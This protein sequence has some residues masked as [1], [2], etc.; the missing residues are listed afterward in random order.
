MRAGIPN[1]ARWMAAILALLVLTRM[2]GLG[3][4][5]L[6]DTTEA[7]YAEIARKMAQLG[8]WVTPWYDTGVPYWG[9]PALSFWLTAMSFK[10]FGV[11]E[12]AARLPHFL[13][14]LLVAWLVWRLGVRRSRREA[15]LAVTLLAGSALFFVAA[16]AVMTDG[17]LVVGTTL[18]MYGFWRGVWNHDA[19]G[20]P[21]RWL[22]FVGI[23]IA[24]LAKGPVALVL[25]G[26][27]LLVWTLA[28][29]ETRAVRRALPWFA[30]LAGVAVLVMP[31]YVL[32]EIRTPGFLNY[33]LV[34][35][36]W[37]RF[38][39]P[40][41]A[42]DLY[43]HAHQVPP[44]TIWLFAVVALL[45]WSVLLPAAAVCWRIRG[46]AFDSSAADDRPWRLYLLLW[47]ITP[48][49]LFTPARNIIWTYVLPALPAVALLAG[50]WLARH[51][52][53]GR[54]EAWL[55]VGL[56]IALLGALGFGMHLER[57]GHADVRSAKALV[58]AH[59][60]HRAD[61]QSLVFVGARPYSAAFYSRGTARRVRDLGELQDALSKG[62]SYV[63]IRAEDAG[64][65]RAMTG[66]HTVSIG[67][68]GDYE[69]LWVA[70]TPAA[71]SSIA[72]ARDV[73]ARD[74]LARLGREHGCRV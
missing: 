2:L 8:D 61:G 72:A 10:T 4:L 23:A 25:I 68:Y 30:G 16:G 70:S 49:L 47:V 62:A 28:C 65:L 26:A 60:R 56:V 21:E 57:S 20:H 43:G 14:A 54:V 6:M 7:R 27:P 52:G 34:G 64:R 29:R 67:R 40:G 66:F 45:P 24:L 74:G 18:A 39:N 32:A 19:P 69:L 15:G 42:G 5:P 73:V 38:V 50:Q 41:W 11:S 17:A 44:G 22:L 9:K 63:A 36:H 3:A 55:S 58:A 1:I 48:L 33:F 31:W 51:P 71:Q 12:F 35:E 53:P 59:E 46:P 13:C 37:R